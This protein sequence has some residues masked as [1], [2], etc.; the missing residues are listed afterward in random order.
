MNTL[1]LTDAELDYIMRCLMA[2]PYGEVAAL[3]AKLHEQANAS[4]AGS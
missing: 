2:R 3:I 4:K 1:T